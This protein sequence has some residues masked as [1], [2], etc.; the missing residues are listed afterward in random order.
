MTRINP[1]LSWIYGLN[2]ICNSYLNTITKEN[3]PHRK[4]VLTTPYWCSTRYEVWFISMK[5]FPGDAVWRNLQ[6]KDGHVFSGTQTPKNNSSRILSRENVADGLEAP[7]NKA[8]NL[9]SSP[10]S[11]E[12]FGDVV[13]STV[14]L[15]LP[16]GEHANVDE[17]ENKTRVG[18]HEVTLRRNI[19]L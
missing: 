7:N 15:T 16:Y 9:D 19:F 4:P 18:L 14:H 17:R 11:M 5:P 12:T 8:T 13:H 1:N 6:S 2:K 3:Y 10:I